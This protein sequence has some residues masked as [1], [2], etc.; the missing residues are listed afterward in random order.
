MDIP[1]TAVYVEGP[2]L[3]NQGIKD[4]TGLEYAINLKELFVREQREEFRGNGISDL[5]PI[6]GLTQLES[7]SIGGIGNHVS[8]LSPIANLTNIKHLDLGGNPISDLSPIAN[9]TQLESISFDDSVPLTDISVLADMK[10]LS[11]PFSCGGH[12]SEI[13]LRW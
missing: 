13:C 2:T 1:K 10:Q 5:T 6:S 3:F 7:L 11:K 4:L 12:D 8:D 9:L